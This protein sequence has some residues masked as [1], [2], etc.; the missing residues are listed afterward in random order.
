M[1]TYRPASFLD[2]DAGLL[3]DRTHESDLLVE[4]GIQSRAFEEDVLDLILLQV[5]LPAAGGRQPGEKVLPI[6]VGRKLCAETPK[7]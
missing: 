6:R 4:E 3:Q 2:L 1:R 5:F 7:T